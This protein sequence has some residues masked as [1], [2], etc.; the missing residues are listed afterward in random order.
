MTATQAAGLTRAGLDR[1]IERAPAHL[2]PV[3]AT[4]RDAGMAFLFVPQ[5]FESFGV[6]KRADRPTIVILGDDMDAAHGPEG[7][8][9]PSL[10]RII[11]A[12]KFFA[13]VSSAPSAEL[14]GS[15][16]ALAGSARASCLLI[17]TRLEQEFQWV[18]LIQRLAP[19]RPIC[20]STVKGGCA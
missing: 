17:E 16:A 5:G 1:V 6:P 2:K 10:R 9:A 3:L 8:H 18:S 20:L 13:V 15:I 11:R 14:Y 7:F 4:V 12:C 19:G